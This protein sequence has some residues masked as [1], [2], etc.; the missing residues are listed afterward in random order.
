MTIF[1]ISLITLGLADAMFFVGFAV[2]SIREHERRAA[3]VSIVMGIAGL[4][5]AS[6]TL[7]CS[8]DLIKTI[9]I[10]GYIVLALAVVGIL[11][12]IG[13]VKP[14]NT[15]PTIRFDERDVMFARGRLKPGSWEYQMYYE[16]RPEN[17]VGDDLT[18]SKPGLLEKGSKYYHPVHFAIPTASFRL[19]EILHQI[20]D[21]EPSDEKF[22]PKNPREATKFV[23]ALAK[24]FGAL[25]ADVTELKD[26]HI[27]SHVGRGTGVYGEPILLDHKFAIAFTVEMDFDMVASNPA[28]PGVLESAKQYVEAARIAVQLA[29]TIRLIGYRA[30]AHIDGNYRVI[31]PLVARDAGLGEI[32]RM[33][34]LI[35]PKYGPRVRIGVVTTDLPL[36]IDTHERD[37]SVLDFCRVCKKC[38]INCP[39]RSIP[40]DDRKEID[41]AYRWKINAD[42]CYRYWHVIGTDCGRCM[43]VCPYSHPNNFY[44]NIVRWASRKSGGF[45]RFAVFMDNLFYGTYPPIKEYVDWFKLEANSS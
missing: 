22:E 16:M 37:A 3:W 39:V 15:T 35:T 32:G 45:R 17:K 11:A 14:L 6:M 27:Y 13:R 41:G 23:I 9:A 20:V 31:A 33:G 26:Y 7:W 21:G 2:I 43:T 42:T 40:M 30:R 10:V 44:H 34:L 38:A 36:A 28:P 25:D 29:E 8:P 18:R 5:L 4:F 12:P 24:Y 1:A 19:T